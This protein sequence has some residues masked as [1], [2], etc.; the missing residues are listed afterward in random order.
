MQRLEAGDCTPEEI[1]LFRTWMAE[2]SFDDATEEL[3]LSMLESVKARMHQLMQEFKGGVCSANEAGWPGAQI[4]SG[5]CYHYHSGGGFALVVP[6]RQA[7][8]GNGANSYCF[9][10]H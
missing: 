8:Y 5:S 7:G 10:G 1:N 6:Q 2:V 4:C 3:T 9:V